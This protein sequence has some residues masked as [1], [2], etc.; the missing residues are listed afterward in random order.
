MKEIL[1]RRKENAVAIRPALAGNFPAC[2][3]PHELCGFLSRFQAA[4]AAGGQPC[5][6]CLR[7]DPIRAEGQR[8]GAEGSQREPG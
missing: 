8:R 1:Q 7:S 5:P 6:E 2:D 3:F 4:A